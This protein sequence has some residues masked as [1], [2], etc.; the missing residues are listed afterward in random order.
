MKELLETQQAMDDIEKEE[1]DALELGEGE[2]EP[3]R[4]LYSSIQ[5]CRLKSD[6]GYVLRSA[7]R[8]LS[9][10]R[11]IC[12]EDVCNCGGAAAGMCTLSGLYPPS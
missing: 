11:R 7:G 9:E 8:G 10:C 2:D 1:Y 4:T 6:D 12:I 3:D 5:Q